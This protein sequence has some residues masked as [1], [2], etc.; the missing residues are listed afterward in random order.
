LNNQSLKRLPADLPI[1]RLSIPA[2]PLGLR[3]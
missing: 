3:G 2:L 1:N